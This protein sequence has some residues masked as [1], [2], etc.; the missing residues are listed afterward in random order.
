MISFAA[1]IQ[2]DRGKGDMR[3]MLKGL[4]LVVLLAAVPAF[5]A[6]LDGEWG[7]AVDS[8]KGPVTVNYTFKANGGKL[9]GT[10]TGPDGS[11]LALKDG[12]IDGAII[13]FAVDVNLDGKPTTLKYTGV[14]AADSIQMIVD[15]QGTPVIINAKRVAAK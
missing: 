1:R 6:G 11:K 14:V 15:V 13:S 8:P 3:T 2:E 7:A 4:L 10:T 12:K 9:T 5:A